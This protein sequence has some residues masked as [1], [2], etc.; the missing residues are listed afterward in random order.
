MVANERIA[1]AR[2]DLRFYRHNLSVQFRAAATLR[3]AFVLQILGMVINNLALLA[4][5]VFLFVHFG[6]INGWTAAE[7]VGLQGIN[8]VIFGT[9][10]ATSSGLMDL[11]R[12]IDQGS[13]DNFLTRPISVL[14]QISSSSIDVT[15]LGDLALGII[16]TTW[17]IAHAHTPPAALILFFLALI[18]GCLLFWSFGMVLPNIMAF[19]IYDGERVSRYLGFVFLDGGLYPTG[20]L[21]GPLRTILLTVFPSLF[22][23]A[24]QLDVLRG[25]H[26][27]L[28]LLGVIIT[29]IWLRAS[30]WLFARSMRRY[31]SANLTG[32]R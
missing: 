4:A 27:W 21:T 20:I 7:L 29:A 1:R 11:P 3:G 23:G 24:V 19:Y 14:A 9:I 18:M 2:D 15:T 28:V 13:F 8:M 6:S 32:A 26:L 10:M 25:L 30:L 16:L 5:W 12:H 22:I 31:E 17:Y